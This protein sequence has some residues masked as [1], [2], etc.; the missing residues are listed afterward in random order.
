VT[1]F[2]QPINLEPA[3]QD[4]ERAKE[5][6][7][8]IW[9]QRSPITAY[10]GGSGSFSPDLLVDS[11]ARCT[12]EKV[13][14]GPTGVELRRCKNM[15]KSVMMVVV[16]MTAGG[17]FAQLQNAGFESNTSGIFGR[18]DFWEPNGGWADHAS[19]ARAGNESLGLNFAFYSGGQ[20]E[21]MGQ[22]SNLTYRAG[23]TYTFW[24]WA[25]GGG[26]DTGTVSYE[27]GYD[28]GTGAFVQLAVATYDLTGLGMWIETDGVSHTALDGGAEI[29]RNVWVRFGDANSGS[30][31]D[32]WLDNVSLIP[33]PG[34]AA[35]L[36][37]GL[38]ATMRRRRA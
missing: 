14:F 38:A 35:V 11:R 32:L 21:T 5:A 9:V 2:S 10:G 28:D 17:A 29:G 18:P 6:N 33:A 3:K 25:I 30:D 22:V 31:N 27:I 12:F 1:D 7:A 37:L 20:S 36:G 16:A 4:D 24:S 15:R 19:F 13:R 34:A 23:S 8:R 26:N